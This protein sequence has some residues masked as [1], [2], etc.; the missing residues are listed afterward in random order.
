MKHVDQVQ[1]MVSHQWCLNSTSMELLNGVDGKHQYST[2]KSIEKSMLGFPLK[3]LKNTEFVDL[4]WKSRTSCMM[5]MVYDGFCLCPC[6]ET[7]LSLIQSIQR[8]EG[9]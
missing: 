4:K 6:V 1:L 7:S 2:E 5:V 3:N 9:L 8:I